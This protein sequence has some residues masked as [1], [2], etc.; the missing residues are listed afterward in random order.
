LYLDVQEER[1]FQKGRDQLYASGRFC[2]KAG[3]FQ[4]CPQPIPLKGLGAGPKKDFLFEKVNPKIEV[5]A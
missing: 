1:K 4:T 3:A 2:G 5:F